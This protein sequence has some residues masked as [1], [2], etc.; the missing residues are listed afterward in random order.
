ML[1][2]AKAPLLNQYAKMRGD[3]LAY[4]KG[5]NTS[6]PVMAYQK[7]KVCT[8]PLHPHPPL[9]F[10]L[11]VARAPTCVFVPLTGR[12]SGPDQMCVSL[13]RFVWRVQPSA[14]SPSPTKKQSQFPPYR[15]KPGPTHKAV[16]DK[17]GASLGLGSN[18]AAA[19]SVE[20]RAST[21]ARGAVVLSGFAPSTQ[22]VLFCALP[23]GLDLTG[24][25]WVRLFQVGF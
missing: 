9:S 11:P 13:S 7:A 6:K 22:P 2:V 23:A 16:D 21:L 5:S 25:G 24:C 4:Y 17:P 18:P 10:H 1:Q 14:K 20:G 3:S 8:H 19:S 15:S 12:A